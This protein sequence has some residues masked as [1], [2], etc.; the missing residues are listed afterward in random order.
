ME[1][2]VIVVLILF[3]TAFL[4]LGIIVLTFEFIW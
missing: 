4:V 2:V 1:K 3:F